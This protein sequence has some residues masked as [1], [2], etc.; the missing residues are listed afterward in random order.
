MRKTKISQEE[1]RKYIAKEAA[2]ATTVAALPIPFVDLA[3][4]VYIQ[5]KL[6][7]KLATLYNIPINRNQK[8]LFSSIIATILSK[9][10]T[11]LVAALAS[12]SSIDQFLSASLIKATIAGLVTG[13][14]GETY[15]LHFRQGGEIE[16]LNF[17]SLLHYIQWQVASDKLSVE[18]ISKSLISSIS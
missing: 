13:A 4:L 18:H 2:K 17:E 7:E 10:T 15:N 11:E 3:G 6:I 14:L 16:D 12:K 1:I 9:L 8:I 5:V